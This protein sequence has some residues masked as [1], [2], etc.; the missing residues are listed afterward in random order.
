MNRRN[1][2]G[3]GRV[4]LFVAA[5]SVVIGC[6]RF[7]ARAAGPSRFLA[8]WAGDAD[9]H[10]EDFLAIIDVRSGSPT[11]GRIM[12]TILVGSKA[13]EP[14][15]VDFSARADGTLWASGL[16]SSRTF[17]F[18]LSRP[19]DGRLVK[20]DAPTSERVHT[21]AHAYATLPD[22]HT[23]ATAMDMMSAE[24]ED[25]PHGEHS[26]AA[27]GGLLEFDEHGNFIRRISAAAQD[28]GNALVSPYGIA[29][30]PE[31]DRFVTTNVGHGWLP[32]AR[33]LMPGTSVQVWRLSDRTVLRTL[34]LE[35]GPRKAEHLGP[36]E[37][38]F[39]NASKSQTV[40]VNTVLGSALYVSTNVAAPAPTFR[41]VHD[42]G[43][44]AILGYSLVTRNDRYYIQA[45]TR[46]NKVAVLDVA[47]PLQ[48]RQVAEVRFDRS[49]ED[50]S[51]TR[52]GQPHF[53]ALDRDDRRLAVSDYVV[54]LPALHADG[55]RRVYL[56]ALDPLTGAL[57]FDRSF[58]DEVTR[59]V[60]VDF[61]REN[62]PHGRTG[63]ARPHGMMFLP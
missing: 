56:L 3:I 8:V 22:G 38:R 7:T 23:I 42:F 63:P 5:A 32:N 53:L 55:D 26:D 16:L 37:P 43:A 39:V 36:Y 4:V 24:Y 28:A 59:S 21:P 15:H 9:R 10:D 49:P 11:F 35:P 17:V 47:D 54:D 1:P 33:A 27:P 12:K 58:R 19:L 40:F 25:T 14:H 46:T 31:I 60:G 57:E 29:V 18:D 34:P 41:L 2:G 61:N 52:Q 45:L 6:D 50:P 13:N 62:W 20:V 30:Q 48:P 51:E 44:D